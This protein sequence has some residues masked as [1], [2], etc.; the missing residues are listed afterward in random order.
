MRL[1]DQVQDHEKRIRA[2]EVDNAVLKEHVQAI[3]KWAGWCLAT[4][5]AIFLVQLANLILG[6]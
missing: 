4:L 3:R 1:E 2:L 6:K 5:G